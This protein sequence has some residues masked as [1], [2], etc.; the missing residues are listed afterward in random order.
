MNTAYPRVL[1]ILA[2][3]APF[4]AGCSSDPYGAKV[5]VENIGAA[6]LHLVVV[7][8]IG[9]SYLVGEMM[10]GERRTVNTYPAGESH[11]VIEHIDRSGSKKELPVDC[12]FEPDYRSTINVKVTG[13]SAVDTIY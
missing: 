3:V 8:V 10:V 4:L 9:N 11:I 5:I 2:V 6:P 7:R 12:Y 13:E 1:I